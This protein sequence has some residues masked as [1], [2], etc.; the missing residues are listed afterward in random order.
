MLKSKCWESLYI[1]YVCNTIKDENLIAD[2]EVYL[3]NHPDVRNEID[4]LKDTLATTN[5]VGQVNLPDTILDDI[6]I[7]VYK[8]LASNESSQKQSIFSRIV[9]ILSIR[10]LWVRGGFV[11]VMLLALGFALTPTFVSLIRSKNPKSVLST[12]SQSIILTQ[13][14]KIE[15]YRQ[16]EIQR[17]FEEAIDAKHLRNDDWSTTSQFRRLRENAK[18][19]DWAEIVDQ[20]I[21][22]AQA[23]SNK[24]L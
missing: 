4:A 24:G 15:Q 12:A 21:Q 20:Q 13:E 2:F 17:H 23:F 19:M 14:K 7:K 18:G 8:R 16:Q 5:L 22:V 10:S 11:T 9:E 1:D 6:E 3:Q